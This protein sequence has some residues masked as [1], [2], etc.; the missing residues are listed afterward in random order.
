MVQVI[1][2]SNNEVVYTLRI[3]GT[4]FSPK[5]FAKGT[6]TIKVGEGENVRTS[7]GVKTTQT[8]SRRTLHVLK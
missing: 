3:L 6:Y 8:K 2:E 4:S 1:D 7:R 5:V